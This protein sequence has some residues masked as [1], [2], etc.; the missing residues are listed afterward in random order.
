MG[1]PAPLPW[2][3]SARAAGTTVRAYKSKRSIG[4]PGGMLTITYWTD[5]QPDVTLRI[6]CDKDHCNRCDCDTDHVI[7]LNLFTA[8]RIRAL[9]HELT[10]Q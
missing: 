5:G 10:E 3:D 7:P 9:L 4:I 6:F 8:G 1:V 2:P